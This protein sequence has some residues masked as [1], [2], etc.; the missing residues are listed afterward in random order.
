MTAELI[1]EAKAWAR[2]IV[3]NDAD[4]IAGFMTE[5]WVMVS[6]SGITRRD[7]FLSA[8]R[9]GRLSHSAMDLV[10]E[11]RVRTY[12]DAA[13]M[14]FRATNTAHFGGE[15]F[16]ADEWTTDVLVHRDGR[17]LCAL[18]HITAVDAPG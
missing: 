14:T 2:A 17:W 18:S 6:G 3:S 16:D 10:S 15:R 1:E 12:A 8:V 11:P 7:D 5:D 4:R 9:S 13:I